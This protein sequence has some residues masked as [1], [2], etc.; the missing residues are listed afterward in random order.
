MFTNVNMIEAKSGEVEIDDI[1]ADVMETMLHFLYNEE[2]KD[3]KLINTSL[4]L[5][6]DKYNIVRLMKICIQPSV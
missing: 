4:L 1:E 2:I 5:A 3:T 6:A